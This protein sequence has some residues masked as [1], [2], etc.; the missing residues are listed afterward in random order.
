MLT[1]AAAA[2]APGK[3]GDRRNGTKTFIV[4][5]GTH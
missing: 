3:G 2:G 5:P 1:A 4:S